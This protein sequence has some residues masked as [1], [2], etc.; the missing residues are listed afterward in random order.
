[1]AVEVL[2]RD[3]DDEQCL[4]TFYLHHSIDGNIKPIAQ[5]GFD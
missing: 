1:L 2:A 3:T 5:I 4:R